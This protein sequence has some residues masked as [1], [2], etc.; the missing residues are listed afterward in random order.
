MII[1]PYP[2]PLDSVWPIYSTGHRYFER[3]STIDKY[4]WAHKP[5]KRPDWNRKFYQNGAEKVKPSALL[6]FLAS[7][8]D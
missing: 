7:R 4:A 2:L 3:E 5:A 6:S 8:L 1:T